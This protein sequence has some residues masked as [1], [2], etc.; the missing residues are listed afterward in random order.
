MSRCQTADSCTGKPAEGAAPQYS[1]WRIH[2]G[3]EEENLGLPNM[4][5]EEIRISPLTK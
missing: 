2:P 3:T 1:P 5:Q 4:D